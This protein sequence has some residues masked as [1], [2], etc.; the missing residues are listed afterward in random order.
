M[1]ELKNC[2]FKEPLRHEG[3]W[4]AGI[5]WFDFQVFDRKWHNRSSLILHSGTMRVHRR[6]SS[7]EVGIFSFLRPETRCHR[8]WDSWCRY[9][10]YKSFT[11]RFLSLKIR[12]SSLYI[13]FISCHFSQVVVF[14][15]QKNET[16]VILIDLNIP[17]FTNYLFP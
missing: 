2:Q 11:K 7:Y 1:T 17:R 15:T 3:T 8:C 9:H 5:K 16:M 4:N 6:F 14:D 12:W 10:L 13:S